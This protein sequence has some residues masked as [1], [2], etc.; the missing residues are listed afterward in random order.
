[1]V[2]EVP[3]RIKYTVAVMNG[4]LIAG[5]KQLPESYRQ[6]FVSHF[7]PFNPVFT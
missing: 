4:I 3:G 5:Y 1:M 2:S 6:I 7:M